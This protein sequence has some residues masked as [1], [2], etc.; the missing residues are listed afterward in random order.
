MYC[1][2]KFGLLDKYQ[3]VQ[4]NIMKKIIITQENSGQRIDRFLAAELFSYSRGEIIRN[5][6]DG[7]ILVGGKKIKPSYILKVSDEISVQFAINSTQ[8]IRNSGLKIKIIHQDEHIIV[9]DKPAG[10]KVH[11]S[12]FS[13][14]NTL[15]N[16]LIA[17]FPE[18]KN[19]N[20]PSTGSGQAS[21]A[22]SEFRPGIVHRLDKDTSGVM[23]VAR[24]QKTFGELKNLFKNRKIEKKYL[25]VVYGKLEKKKGVIDSPLARAENYKK[26]VIAGQK[27][28]TKIRPAITEYNVV[29]EFAN[30]SLLEAYPKTGRMHQIRIHLTSIGH[31]I[32]GDK[33]YMLKKYKII[34]MVKRQMLH[35]E[36]LKFTLFE[37]DYS[38]QAPVPNDMANLINNLAIVNYL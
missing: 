19:I 10:L 16:F 34:N 37:Q 15:V 33:T 30:H 23:V 27:T 38:F 8:L 26:Q 25:A 1:L 22:G 2:G 35:A 31:P 29:Q 20:D 7:N 21:S 6:K 18:I 4:K 14:N 11:P 24:N 32:V 5:I 36:T 12:D 9:V 28:K 13:E 3:G 17:H